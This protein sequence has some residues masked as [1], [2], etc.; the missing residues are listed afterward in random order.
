MT[1]D[2]AGARALLL[3]GVSREMLS[4]GGTNAARVAYVACRCV[5]HPRMTAEH[6]LS[7]LLDSD[8]DDVRARA[9]EWLEKRT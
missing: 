3:S 9:I 1:P 7:F 8:W 6:G 2:Y 4:L 5:P